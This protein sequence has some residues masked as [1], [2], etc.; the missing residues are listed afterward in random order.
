MQKIQTLT[1]SGYE[2]AVEH[3]REG[4]PTTYGSRH[5]Q[6]TTKIGDR[7]H[8]KH[9]GKVIG[10]IERDLV[11]RE[12]KT[13]GRMYVNSRWKSPG[14]RYGIGEPNYLRQE[15]YSKKDAIERIMWHLE[16]GLSK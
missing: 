6:K 14:W 7:W 2:V 10:I 3:V 11:T 13:P 1:I 4:T 5:G 16:K 9:N 15:A 12:Q 8:V